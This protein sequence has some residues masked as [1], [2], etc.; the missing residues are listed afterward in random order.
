[1]YT[2]KDFISDIMAIGRILMI[3][4]V[5]YVVVSRLGEEFE[6]LGLDG[7]GHKRIPVNRLNSKSVSLR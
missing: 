1:M 6:L 5:P 7:S 2:D 3:D 4:K